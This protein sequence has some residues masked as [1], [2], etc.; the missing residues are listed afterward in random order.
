MSSVIR[1]QDRA[2]AADPTSTG[3]AGT[4]SAMTEP[5][6]QAEDLEAKTPSQTPRVV[7]P[8]DLETLLT[9]T[10]LNRVAHDG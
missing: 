8:I 1:A 5:L 4:S 10:N 3:A 7:G 9:S 2:I 6:G